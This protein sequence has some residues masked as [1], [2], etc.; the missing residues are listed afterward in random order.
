MTD[1]RKKIVLMSLIRSSMILLFIVSII[2]ISSGELVRAGALFIALS[3]INVF[4][5]GL[6]FTTFWTLSGL[7]T[8]SLGYGKQVF[9]MMLFALAA[10]I[11]VADV[12]LWIRAIKRDGR[13]AFFRVKITD[14][15]SRIY[16]RKDFYRDNEIT[17]IL[18]DK[19]KMKMTRSVPA[20]N[21]APEN[22]SARRPMT[23][24]ERKQ[25]IKFLLMVSAAMILLVAGFVFLLCENL[26]VG[27][28]LFIIAGVITTFF[29]PLTN[30]IALIGLMMVFLGYD[31]KEIGIIFGVIG[32]A[33]FL[34]NVILLCK[35]ITG[36][37]LEGL[38]IRGK[39]NRFA[40]IDY[41]KENDVTHVVWN[42]LKYH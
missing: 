9:A 20:A 32:L 22:L 15:R 33:I 13:M 39:S 6:P 3:A 23:A 5:Y 36:G 12:I 8:V 28:I 29:L 7:G 24:N 1:E 16:T 37:A 34:A 30:G 10:V 31:K 21:Q 27:G 35:S 2:E 41:L 18:W 42:K 19:L 38:K 4:Y 17:C 14:D 11:V 25:F 40:F 26:L